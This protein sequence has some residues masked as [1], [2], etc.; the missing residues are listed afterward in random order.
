MVLGDKRGLELANRLGLAVYMLSRDNGE[1]TASYS[2][3][4]EPYMAVATQQAASEER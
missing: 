4:F 1:F 3:T 2:K